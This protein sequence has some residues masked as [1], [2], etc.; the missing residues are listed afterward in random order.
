MSSRS[1]ISVK[2]ASTHNLKAVD[3][4]IP[5]QKLTVV[6]GLSGSGKSSLAFDTL[7]AEGQRRYVSS[8]STYARQFLERLP[9][10]E[11]DFISNLPPAI[12]VEQRNGVNNARATVGS[13]TELLDH[14]RV[15]FSKLGRRY[16]CGQEVE[17]GTVQSISDKILSVYSS[18]RIYIGSP[19]P[20]TKKIELELLADGYTRLLLVDGEILEIDDLPSK[21][22]SKILRE[23]LSLI[24]R[25]EVSKRHR[26]RLTEAI[27]NG[28]ARGAGKLIVHPLS[29]VRRVFYRGNVCT[30]CGTKY[31][32]PVP[33]LFSWNSALGACST[34]EGFGRVPAL[35]LEKLIPDKDC[36]LCDGA[37][38]PFATPS[39]RRC[40]RDFEKACISDDVP[41]TASWSD[42]SPSTQAWVIE[43]GPGWYGVRGFFNYLEKKRYKVQNRIIIARYRR[44]DICTD[45]EGSRLRPESLGV[46]LEDLHIGD[47]SSMT[48]GQLSNWLSQLDLTSIEL[49]KGQNLISHLTD[50]VRTAERVGLGYLE[51]SRQLRTVSG[52]EAQR[53]QLA[54]ALG[55][56][57]TSS[58]YVLDEPSVGLH[59]R[60]V[61]KL[62]TVLQ[63]IRAQGNTV[64]VVEHAP[65][66]VRSADHIIELGPE[67]GNHGG[68]IIASGT[69]D[70][71]A[72]IDA[73]PTG[74]VIR[75]EL[76]WRARS[77]LKATGSL[78]ILGA[79]EN[80]LKNVDVEV[81]LGQ[82]VVVSGVSGAGKSTL[83]RQ[84]LVGHLLKD[85]ERGNCREI[86]GSSQISGV[87]LVEPTP[88]GKSRRSNPATISKAFDGIRKR[89]ASTRE[90]RSRGLGPGWFSFNRPGGRCEN[91]EGTGELVVDMQ[92]LEDVR[93][94]CE[95]CK[96]TRFSEE[97]NSVQLEGLSVVDIL[98]LSIDEAH[99]FFSIDPKITR[100]LKPFL[101]VGLGY[102]RLSQS[103]LSLSGGELQ[104]LKIGLALAEDAPGTLYV[105]DEPT[106]GL[107]PVEV[108]QL[109]ACLDDLLGQGASVVVIEHNLEVIHQADWVIDMGPDGGP[110][111]GYVVAQGTPEQIRLNE[112]SATGQVLAETLHGQKRPEDVSR[113]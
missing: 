20:K 64:V 75:N 40:Q 91:C 4:E 11:V 83:I 97:A 53:I 105:L 60:D 111:G 55:G 82:L 18:S 59:A 48:I 70:E 67:A 104:R 33:A 3:C 30:S 47:V 89:L 24:D 57:L 93:V 19:I 100:R 13:A 61:A 16:C 56:T 90:A 106:T 2:G 39:G 23:S 36:Q 107:H 17:V 68:E 63:D 29:G 49:A 112:N 35:D 73:S 8:L 45:C 34:C 5:L 87:I 54:T 78:K 25:I 80:N 1:V 62:L 7:Y 58:L 98:D 86:Q 76:T 74:K 79:N 65:E 81:P 108:Q 50:R 88:P 10:P 95:F 84:V 72:A 101:K 28:L 15:L 71:V 103:L 66:I 85:P 77:K 102:L 46:L 42:L 22:R 94:P 52:G 27:A 21:G 113:Q 37:I 51:L 43:G 99:E 69:I 32:E 96:G 12:A 41:I 110:N 92:F 109:L 14:L 9:R 26:S 38:A 44:F 6:S 31:P